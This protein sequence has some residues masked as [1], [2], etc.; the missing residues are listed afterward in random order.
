LR[1]WRAGLRKSG[2]KLKKKSGKS[3]GRLKAKNQQRRDKP[4]G[5]KINLGFAG[6][7]FIAGFHAEEGFATGIQKELETFIPKNSAGKRKRSSE[8]TP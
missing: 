5:K 4:V 3:S 8:L 6:A 1:N 2:N 7:G